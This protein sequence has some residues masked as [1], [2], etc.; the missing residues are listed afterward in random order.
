MK[1]PIF[2]ISAHVRDSA[3]NR[4]P[5]IRYV[6]RHRRGNRSQWAH[7]RK[8]TP[9]PEPREEAVPPAFQP[10]GEQPGNEENL[11]GRPFVGPAGRLPE[12]GLVVDRSQCYVINAVKY[13]RFEQRGKRRSHD[14]PNGGEVLSCVWWLRAGAVPSR[15]GPYR[16][17]GCE[18]SLCTHRTHK[19]RDEG[20]RTCPFD[21]RRHTSFRHD[22]SFLSAAPS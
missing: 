7:R 16:G 10:E 21:A 14:H 11:K 4:N 13:F 19:R 2:A 22:T 12:E 15:S 3:I 1:W 8:K 9:W 6:S 5:V 20:P 17:N 18:R